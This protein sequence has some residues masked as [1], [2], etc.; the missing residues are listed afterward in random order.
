[1]EQ[2][3]ELKGVAFSYK[4]SSA[5]VEKQKMTYVI[6][7]T[8]AFKI[9]FDIYPSTSSV[10][11]TVN[12]ICFIMSR[13]LAIDYGSKRCGIAVTDNLQIIAKGLTTVHSAELIKWLKD[14]FEKEIVERVVIGLPKDL[15]NEKTDATDLV[16]R[17]VKHFKKTFPD[18]IIQTLDERFTSKMAKDVIMNSGLKKKDRRNKELV[19]EISAGIILGGYLEM[20]NQSFL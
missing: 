9:I 14:Y 5:G 1:M 2:L 7:I 4:Q 20:K 15:R 19:D 16:I 11:R 13:I 3:V 10:C 12:Y 6:K 18:M 17:F 8:G